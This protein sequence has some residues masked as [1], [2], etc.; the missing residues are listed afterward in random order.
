MDFEKL[1]TSKEKI[2]LAYVVYKEHTLG[3]L[4]RLGSHLFLGTLHGKVLKGGRDWKNGD[5]M[6]HDYEYQHYRKA[7]EKDFDDFRVSSKGYVLT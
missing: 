1:K 6:L 3:Y 7:T 4:Y 5:W 2:V